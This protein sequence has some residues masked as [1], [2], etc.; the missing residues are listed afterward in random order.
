M[1]GEDQHVHHCYAAKCGLML[2]SDMGWG[3]VAAGQLDQQAG[4]RQD[5]VVFLHGTNQ[6]DSDR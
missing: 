6:L 3:L 1:S 2:A 5:G 4:E